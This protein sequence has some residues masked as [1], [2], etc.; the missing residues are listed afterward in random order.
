MSETPVEASAE[1]Q[2]LQDLGPLNGLPGD[3]KFINVIGKRPIEEEWN[4]RPDHWLT[5]EQAVA[6]RNLERKYTGTGL[7]TGSR[8]GRLCWLD[9]DGEE[10]DE[11][12]QILK[13]ATLDFEH[14][15]CR[16][17]DDLPPCPINISGRPGRFRALFRVPEVWTEYFNGFSIKGDEMPTKAFEFLYEK[18]G[19]KLFH[20]VIDGKHPDGQ[21]WHYR[22]VEGKSPSEMPI[23]DLTSW[24]IAG[25]VRHIARKAQVREERDQR[26]VERS[27]ESPMD[28]LSPG[29]QIKV[30]AQMSEFWPFRG[31]EAGTK[32]AGHYGTMKR[33]VLSL[34]KGIDDWRVFRHWL[35][36]SDW[37]I[38]NDWDGSQ[39]SAPVA[40]G[41][42]EGFAKSLMRSET[43]GEEVQPWAAAWAIAVENGWKP[44]KWALPPREIDTSKLVV[45]VSKKV[46]QLK[47]A[48]Q[49]IDDMESPLDRVAA[50][51]NLGRALEVSE[52][53]LKMLLNQAYEE[54]G[55]TGIHGG[56]WHEVLAQAKPIEVAVERL[57][58][59][60][61]LT[62][63]GSDGG[64]GKS[65]LIY[66]IAEAAANGS[67]FAG[68]L[69]TVKGN[70]LIIQKDE[71]DSNLAQ[72]DKRMQLRVPKGTVQVRFRFNAG[73]FPE[74]RKWI[75]EHQARYVLMDSMVSLFGGGTDLSEGEIG[76]YMYLLNKI[77]AEE[78]CAI[79]LTHHLR[80]ADKSKGGVRQ[81]I[82]MADLYGSA[83]IG[84]GTS[85]IWGI[86]RD[87]E[88]NSDEPKF[89]LKVLKPRTGVTEGGDTFLL[90]GSTEDLS[91]YVEK[92][93]SDETGVQKLRKG[94]AKL[95]EILRKRTADNPL[96][97]VELASLSG[98]SDKTVRR[99]L[100][101]LMEGTR[102]GIKRVRVE[103]LGNKPK[104]GYWAE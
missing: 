75:R 81:D 22:W 14:L 56:E 95:L 104:Y 34:A 31:G 16:S 43:E 90:S 74:L 60:N 67:L 26:A 79:L 44:P 58:A 94:A 80:K 45:G 18:R 11:N 91:F 69:Q 76:T 87:P 59:F 13:S 15:F 97:R 98:M 82:T 52:K 88:Q 12:G 101:E 70:V 62:I 47:Q 24:M 37:D 89:L 40:E 64:V 83:F 77:A 71:S 92:L 2:V 35:V 23:P 103:S 38:R 66:R 36:D 25:L 8:A 49:I 85:D 100:G 39:G 41:C 9:F 28:L 93:N 50:Y 17:V 27:G 102:Y 57:L 7:M 29:K 21:G 68:A 33:L 5:A 10:V 42:L 1:Q 61:A 96:S 55:G 84:A 30:L 63:V 86:I 32:F 3:A 53:E 20:A 72:K 48:L 6:Q 99:L 73:M 65:V 78:G 19:G 4:T 51:Q 46:E 54:D